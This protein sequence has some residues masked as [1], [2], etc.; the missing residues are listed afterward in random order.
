MLQL[1]YAMYFVDL[2]GYIPVRLLC[3]IQDL[4]DLEVER[5]N[6]GI[7]KGE[8][9]HE[10]IPLDCVGHQPTMPELKRAHRARVRE[11]KK[12]LAV[13]L[14]FKASVRVTRK[15]KRRSKNNRLSSRHRDA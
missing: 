13:A 4:V 14:R 11:K 1:Y 7:V 6:R 5:R 15:Q 2:R 10:V 9:P 8:A 3:V 12:E